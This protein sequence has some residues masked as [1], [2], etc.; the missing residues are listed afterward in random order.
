MARIVHGLHHLNLASVRPVWNRQHPRKKLKV[1]FSNI[2]E[3][4]KQPRK[5]ELILHLTITYL[6]PL[7][8][9]LSASST[10]HLDKTPKLLPA[11]PHCIGLDRH[12]PPPIMMAGSE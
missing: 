9:L 5:M 1:A 6:N 2:F 12:S 10:L 7:Q 4:R 8:A 11:I 3:R